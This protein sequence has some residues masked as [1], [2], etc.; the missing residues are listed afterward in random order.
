MADLNPLL[1]DAELPDFGRILPDHVVPATERLIADHRRAIDAVTTAGASDFGSVILPSERADFELSRGWSPVSHLNSVA[2]TPAL[3]AAHAEAEEKLTAYLMEA[4]QNRALHEA[5]GRVAQSADFGKLSAP[6]RRAVELALRGFRLSGVALEGAARERFLEIGVELSRLSTRFGNA[7][8]DATEA[9]T[10]HVSDEAALAGIPATDKAIL[11]A[12]A[13]EKGLGGWLVT[14]RQPSVMAVL[15]HAADRELRHRVYRAYNTRASDQA[16]APDFDNSQRIEEIMALRHEAAQLLGF[17]D[18][19]AL[20]LETKMAADAEEA[21]TFLFDLAHRARPVAEAELASA[22]AFAQE[23]FGIEEL[24][25]WDLNYV[26]E[27][28]RR[29]LHGV[30]QEAIKAYLPFPRVMRGTFQLIERLYGVRLVAREGVATWHS[31][32]VYCD[33][34]DSGGAIVAGVYLD[35]YARSGKRGGAWMDVCR[36]RFRDADRFHKPVAY[37]TT[38][39]APPAGDQPSLLTHGDVETF[40]HEFGHV[41]HHLLTEVDLPSIGGI[42]GVEWD[43]VELPSQFMENFAWDRASLLPLTGHVET[44]EPL[45]ADIFDRMLA[46]RHF[47]SGLLLLRQIEFATFDMML[48]RDFDP[49]QGAKVMEA[50]AKVRREIAVFHPPEWNRFPHAFGHIF[51]GGYAAGYYSYL[52]AELLSSDAFEL[53]GTAQA[54]GGGGS[55]FCR[56]ILAVGA[57]RTAAENFQAFAG[58]PPQIDALLRMR[59]LA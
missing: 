50:L 25:P 44:G 26:A 8:L 49:E 34:V 52:W 19:A 22:R 9:W 31:D 32:V 17:N 43:A 42:S 51:A 11:A 12:Y 10:E 3:R 6:Q 20:S 59:G 23:K 24:E 28:M 18:S 15:S 57:S 33:L 54:D 41:L 58:R 53:F 37:L 48:H 47:Q 16:A 21:L 30:D 7:V 14:L 56:E 45:P 39:F 1:A 13:R 5:I 36:P 29:T 40:L 55:A 4:G 35:L 38:N 46:A 2:D 27:A